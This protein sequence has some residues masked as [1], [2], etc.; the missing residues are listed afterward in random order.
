MFVGWYLAQ[1]FSG[2]SGSS[3]KFY[4]VFQPSYWNP[5]ERVRTSDTSGTVMREKRA[6]QAEGSARLL[7][8]SKSYASKTAVSELSLQMKKNEIFCLLGQNGAGKS[9][10]IN[11]MTGLHPITHGEA[12]IDGYSVR[13]DM[14]EIQSFMGI[15]PQDNVPRHLKIRQN[16]AKFCKRFSTRLAA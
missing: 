14:H 12:F 3:K 7:K 11:V 8:V 16:L 10:T 4:F 13:D 15:C 5:R 2:G 9:T 1:I 6:S